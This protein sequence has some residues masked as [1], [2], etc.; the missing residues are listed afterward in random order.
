MKEQLKVLILEDVPLDAELIE[1]ELHHENLK[2]TSKRVETEKEFNKQ[3]ENFKPH[4]ILAD[5]S[6]P[7]YDGISALQ[8]TRKKSPH[9][10]FIF[11]SG[12]IGNE[13][14]AKMLKKGATDYVYKNNLSKL[15]PAIKRALNEQEEVEKLYKS[16]NT[17]KELKKTLKELERSNQELENF[18]YVA[19]HDLQEPLRM[20]SSFTQLLKKQYNDKLDETALEYINYAAN[21]AKQM[22]LLIN[23]LLTYSRINTNDNKFMNI[24][25]E[26]AL[27]EALFNLEIKIEETQAIITREPLPQI[28]ADYS[29]L[30]RVFQNLIGNAIKYRSQETPKIHISTTKKDQN[31]QFSVKDNGIGIQPKYSEQ[32]FQIFKRLHTQDEYE[33][34]GIGLAITKKIIEL[35]QGQ[36]WYD[37]QPGNGSTFHFT[38]PQTLQNQ[39]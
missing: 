2:F 39:I 35:H 5:H 14:T 27:D 10:P 29:Q 8:L 18:A 17:E 16:K 25:L 26:K 37:S 13:F 22:Q 19:S 23:D 12:K 15:T 28:Y 9:T 24:K 38:I 34:T 20:V 21:G 32:V 3:L 4:I 1:Y 31:W 30:V 11:V 36:I 7:H 6:L 33:G